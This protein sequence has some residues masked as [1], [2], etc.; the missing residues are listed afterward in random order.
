MSDDE[1]LRDKVLRDA[2]NKSYIQAVV[3]FNAKTA[4]EKRDEERDIIRIPVPYGTVGEVHFESVHVNG[5]PCFLCSDGTI[6][7]EIDAGSDYSK[8]R[9]YVPMDEM[10]YSHYD[11]TL[12]E[13]EEFKRMKPYDST[14]L[15]EDLYGLVLSVQTDYLLC[16]ENDS[17]VIAAGIVFSY[18]QHMSSSTPYFLFIG[19]PES[20]KTRGLQLFGGLSYRPLAAVSI[21][22]ANI[23]RYLGK[24]LD[25]AGTV[26]IDEAESI[27]KND[28][29]MSLLNNGYKRGQKVP[30]ITGRENGKQEYFNTYC[31]KA[32]SVVRIPKNGPF[33]SR[34]VKIKMMQGVPYKVDI[35]AEDEER[36]RAIRKQLLALRLLSS[37][38]PLP[39]IETPLRGRSRELYHPLLRVMYGT[40]W[41]DLLLSQLMELDRE[42]KEI[43]IESKA[44][45]IARAVIAIYDQNTGGKRTDLL[46]YND[47]VIEKMGLAEV[48]IDG[49]LLLGSEELPF[50]TTKNDLGRIQS[51]NLGAKPGVGKDSD[52]K[53][54]RGHWYRPEVI[55]RLRQRYIAIEKP[56]D[57][58]QTR[59]GS[60]STVSTVSTPQDAKETPGDLLPS[61]SLDT[62]VRNTL[63]H[64]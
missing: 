28:D 38:E 33:L 4:R 29:L 48:E 10:P 14:K 18:F 54:V 9:L 40:K 37:Q 12:E 35:E 2:R 30:R 25:G 15:K 58:A 11:Y 63:S 32:M 59:L 7:E 51:E 24:D 56:G 45:Y 49:K 44:G 19:P 20:G 62:K 55:E 34:C 16:E 13:I 61:D 57:A 17:R 53:S 23:F 1:T 8:A 21:T 52:R 47:E 5:R 22:G 43:D 31:I 50:M 39:K 42:R 3:E 36:F 60:L 27:D 26:L 41:Y 6:K 46:I 64:A